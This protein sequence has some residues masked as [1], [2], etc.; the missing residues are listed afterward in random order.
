MDQRQSDDHLDYKNESVTLDFTF[1]TL[2]QNNLGGKGPDSGPELMVFS[3]ITIYDNMSLN[4][5]IA[6]LGD[7]AGNVSKNKLRGAF[8]QI[9]L[10]NNRSVD[11]RF[12]F[13][14]NATGEKVTIPRFT[15]SFWDLDTGKHGA[16]ETMSAGPIVAYYTSEESEVNATRGDYGTYWMFSGTKFGRYSDNPEDIDNVTQLQQNRAVEVEMAMRN[17]F[18]NTYS[19]SSAGNPNTGRNFLIGGKSKLYLP[20]PVGDCEFLTR[21]NFGQPE[22]SL[23]EGGLRFRGVARKEGTPVD[24]LITADETYAAYNASKTGLRGNLININMLGNTTTTFTLKFVDSAD[25]PVNLKRFYLTLL[26]LD[27]PK[28]GNESISMANTFDKYFVAESTSLTVTPSATSTKFESTEHGLEETNPTDSGNLSPYQQSLG[29]S[30]FFKKWT[31]EVKLTYT[32]QRAPYG[33]NFQIAELTEIGCPAVV[34][35]EALQR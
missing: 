30:L 11:L 26:D 29:A 7:Y 3:N 31:S 21:L 15:F 13:R 12:T 28:H 2:S 27:G 32:I 8:G 34:K 5:E 35:A 22:G 10:L 1:A 16:V 6:A 24:L 4:L 17:T 23:E 14:D 20:H 19:V 33:R 25:K 9:N 18:Y